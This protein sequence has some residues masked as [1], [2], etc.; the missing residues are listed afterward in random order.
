MR[1]VDTHAYTHTAF[2]I[3]PFYKMLL[4]KRITL[5]DLEAVDTEFYSSMKYILDNDPEP[6]CLDFTVSR[7]SLGR[8]SE[9]GRVKVA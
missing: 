4:G 5:D 1:I 3:R 7:E 8:V 9:S 2:F 6:L